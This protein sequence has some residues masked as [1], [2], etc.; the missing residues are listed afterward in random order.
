MQRVDWRTARRD[1]MATIVADTASDAAAFAGDA[2]TVVEWRDLPGR[3]RFDMPSK[4]FQI[5]TMGHGLVVSCHSDWLEWTRERAASLDRNAF[6]APSHISAIVSLLGPSGLELVGPQMRY[7]CSVDTLRDVKGLPGVELSI[8]EGA[9]MGALGALGAFPN[10]LSPRPNPLR[11]DTLAVTA[12]VSGEVIACAG[13]SD[14]NGRLWQIGVDVLEPWQG[15]GI[16]RAIV[17]RLTEAILDAGKVPYYSHSI[18][19]VRSAALATSLG[20]WPAWV[21]WYALEHR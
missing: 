8:V 11:P 14:E 19:N 7:G 13:A 3:R 15:R 21:Q 1:I 16:G 4:P 6:L 5:F 18:S 9:A 12:S 10:A 17:H 20:F 2:I